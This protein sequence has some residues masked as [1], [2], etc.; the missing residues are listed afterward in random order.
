MNST[1][2]ESAVWLGD[3]EACLGYMNG[4]LKTRFSPGIYQTATDLSQSEALDFVIRE[5]RK[6]LPN[7][8]L[9]WSD[10]RRFTY[11]ENQTFSLRREMKGEVHELKGKDKR[12]ILLAPNNVIERSD[13][14]QVPR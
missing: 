11:L 13:V 7:R 10:I 9:R 6:S 12:L 1:A 3:V 5:R 14:I 4:F 8:G 2:A